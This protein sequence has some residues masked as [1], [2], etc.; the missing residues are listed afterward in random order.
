[1]QDSYQSR[2][3]Q[4]HRPHHHIVPPRSVDLCNVAEILLRDIDS[5]LDAFIH[6]PRPPGAYPNAPESAAKIAVQIE[7]VNIKYHPS[8][9]PI[10]PLFLPKTAGLLSITKLPPLSSAT[11][12]PDSS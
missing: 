12:S 4:A 11:T 1:M 2:P 3:L 5:L 8:L 9:M 6:W 7:L 10:G